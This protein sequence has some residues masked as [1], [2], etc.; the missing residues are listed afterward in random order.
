MSETVV[1]PLLRSEKASE[2]SAEDIA[3]RWHV[4]EQLRQLPTDVFSR[5]QFMHPRVGCFNRC[6]FCAQSAGRDIWQFTP[7]GQ[8][9]LFAAL[10][11]V[12]AERAPK[13]QATLAYGRSHRPGVIFPYFDNDVASYPY[14]YEFVKFLWED[15]GAKVRITTVGFSSNNSAL[16]DM[17]AAL[18]RDF[19]HVIAG[20]RFSFTPYTLGWT[21]TGARTDATSREQFIDDFAE[22]L[23]IY[24]PL[25]TKLG[26]SKEWGCCVEI[27]FAPLVASKVDVITTKVK[28]RRVISA[29]EHLLVELE[30]N[31]HQ[32]TRS[33]LVRVVEGVPQYSRRGERYLLASCD[34]LVG[35]PVETSVSRVLAGEIPSREV[36]VAR[37]TNTDG[38]YYAIDWD[39]AEDGSFRAL[40]VYPKTAS[41]PTS[42]FIDATRW[43]LN[44]LLAYKRSCG[45]GRRDAF[46]HATWA[47]VDEVIGRL[48][49]MAQGQQEFYRASAEHI[50]VNILP[51]VEGYA[52]ALKRA[53]YPPQ[54]FFDRRFTVDTGQITNLGRARSLFNG[55]FSNEDDPS[56]PREERGYGKNSISA[57]RGLVWRLTPVPF[58]DA[59][60]APGRRG[61]KNDI[62][63][64]GSIDVLE[65][66]RQLRPIDKSTGHP[67]RAY[68]LH[69][70][71]LEHVDLTA[72]R[73][74]FSYP[75][76]VPMKVESKLKFA[77]RLDPPAH[78]YTEVD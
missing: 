6:A 32:A 5:M 24:R 45:I 42:G 38:E 27:R 50:R 57:G 43:F 72:G 47:D 19:A 63:E 35:L 12:A 7:R 17:H 4:V 21:E 9:N 44:E 54:L 3:A 16:K 11:L 39:F 34:E 8:R 75:G 61:G 74:M 33:R 41:R 31:G 10:A 51:L 70:V 18:V 76:L 58:G 26:P 40:H 60:K 66:D 46:D 22:A 65:L 23:R 49:R 69:G 67:L 56:T 68:R 29:R 14:L 62:S 20:M 52:T 77:P 48:E 15:L 2:V 37:F 36:H 64:A 71:E 78:I 30:P 59:A 73:E 53:D 25:L 1:L 13:S 28:D 55:L